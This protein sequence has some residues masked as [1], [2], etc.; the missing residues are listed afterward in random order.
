VVG[1]VCSVWT[2]DFAGKGLAI[3]IDL[4]TRSVRAKKIAACEFA[5]RHN[6]P[7]LESGFS[8]PFKSL[9]IL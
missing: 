1:Y 4:P 9:L 7:P 8:I 3:F 2:G 5:D 6:Y